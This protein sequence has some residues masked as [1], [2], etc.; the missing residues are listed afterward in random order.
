MKMKKNIL[1]VAMF[2]AL[3]ASCDERQP[4]KEIAK[5]NPAD[6]KGIGPVKEV[7]LGAINATEAAEGKKI[8]GLKCASCH[9]LDEKYVGPA[10]KGVSKR[11][12]PV[13]IMNMILNPLVRGLS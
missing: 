8:F 1:I 3:F 7:T 6:N 11:R 12:N 13:W 2:L 10:L 9:K 5:E 4:N